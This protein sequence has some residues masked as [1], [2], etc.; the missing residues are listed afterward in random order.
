MDPNQ[1]LKTF[2]YP[3]LAC[4]STASFVSI[5]LSLMPI[6][7]WAKIQNDCIERTVAF[8]GLPDRVWSCNGGGH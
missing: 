1:I 6:S 5:A 8:E 4:V 2:G 3:F 7:N